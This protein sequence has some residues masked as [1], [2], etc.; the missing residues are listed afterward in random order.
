MEAS[1]II[2]HLQLL[3]ISLCAVLGIFDLVITQSKHTHARTHTHGKKPFNHQKKATRHP[4]IFRCQKNDTLLPTWST[5]SQQWT[6]SGGSE[7]RTGNVKLQES[8]VSLMLLA[9][10]WK[11][12]ARPPEAPQR[13]FLSVLIGS[14][15]S[16]G[17]A[18]L[19]SLA[20]HF[21]FSLKRKIK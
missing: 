12:S 7:V 15:G 13:L 21:P 11:R 17:S 2:H 9:G 20:Q 1:F 3:T 8:A 18:H 10:L 16:S 4:T 6:H 5:K 19:V 14:G